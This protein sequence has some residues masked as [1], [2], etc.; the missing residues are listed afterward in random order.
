MKRNHQ[1]ARGRAALC[2]LLPWILLGLRASCQTNP[3]TMAELQ[4]L[5]GTWEGAVVG[6]KSDNKITITITGSSFHFHRDTNFWFETTILKI[7]PLPGLNDLQPT[8]DIPLFGAESAGIPPA[9]HTIPPAPANP[10]Q[11]HVTIKASAHSQRDAIGKVVVSLFKIEDGILTVAA[12]GD[13]SEAA[14]TSFDDENVTRYE[15]RKLPPH[16]KKNEPT[17]AK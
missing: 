15:L 12:R 3:P 2:L 5:Q 10:Q 7:K 4:P 13:G 11:L 16:E 8:P 17:T 1:Q 6:E 9:E 14:P